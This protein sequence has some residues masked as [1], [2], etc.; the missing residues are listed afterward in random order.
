MT[1]FAPGNLGGA[2]P[3]IQADELTGIMERIVQDDFVK[4][5]VTLAASQI[6]S[7]EPGEWLKI[8]RNN[9]AEDPTKGWFTITV[10]KKVLPE[11]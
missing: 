11:G 9:P 3:N 4:Q 10:S 6:A 1:E 7:L 5:A 2:G 8:E